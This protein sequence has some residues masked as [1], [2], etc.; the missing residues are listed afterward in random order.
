MR[1]LN[2]RPSVRQNQTPLLKARKKSPLKNTVRSSKQHKPHDPKA[3]KLDPRSAV[4]SKEGRILFALAVGQDVAVA[5][6][7][8]LCLGPNSP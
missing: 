6:S 3:L 7:L 5:K 4:P 8:Y 1:L 2:P